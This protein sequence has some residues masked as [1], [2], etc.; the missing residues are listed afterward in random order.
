MPIP[1]DVGER[2]KFH[3]YIREYGEL[4]NPFFPVNKNSSYFKYLLDIKRSR[5]FGKRKRINKLYKKICK[6]NPKDCT[7]YSYVYP[8]VHIVYPK[9]IFKEPRYFPFED[10]LAPVPTKFEEHFRILFGNSWMMLPE[11]KE[12]DHNMSVDLERPFHVYTQ[13]YMYCVDRKQ[14]FNTYQKWK[15]WR[16]KML[17]KVNFCNDIDLKLQFFKEI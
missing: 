7:H 16:L 1:N 14:L 17:K 6:F 13:D 8:R 2:E 12:S 4:V 9:E 3:R 11:K 15:L 10:M 5:F